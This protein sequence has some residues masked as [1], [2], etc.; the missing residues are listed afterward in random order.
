M[1]ADRHYGMNPAHL[2]TADACGCFGIVG[3][4]A[5]WGPVGTAAALLPWL[6]LNDRLFWRGGG[7]SIARPVYVLIRT[8]E[9]GDGGRAVAGLS[10]LEH[11]S[12]AVQLS[13]R[14]SLPWWRWPSPTGCFTWMRSV[15][16]YGSGWSWRFPALASR[17]T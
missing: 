7:R 17:R 8:A 2:H 14:P 9:R 13:L 10:H 11:F 1:N 3:F 5:P 12:Y 4:L 6:H 16:C 15:R